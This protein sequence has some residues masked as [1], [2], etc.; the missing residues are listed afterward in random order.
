MRSKAFILRFLV[1]VLAGVLALA[2][3]ALAQDQPASAG[4]SGKEA[5]APK[6]SAAPDQKDAGQDADPLKRPL[7][8]KQRKKSQKALYKELS[9]ADKRW[10]DEDVR[11]IITDE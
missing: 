7:N 5:Q 11:W 1:A 6:D 9:E 8:E 3:S 2:V 10:L 4:A